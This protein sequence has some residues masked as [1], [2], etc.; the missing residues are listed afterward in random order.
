MHVVTASL[1]NDVDSIQSVWSTGDNAIVRDLMSSDH[2]LN[3]VVS[4]FVSIRNVI[5]MM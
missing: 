1:F 2:L 5:T 4:S 3:S